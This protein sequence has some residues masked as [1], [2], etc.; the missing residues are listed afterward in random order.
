MRL[1]TF[2]GPIILLRYAL[3]LFYNHDS[4]GFRP[5]DC[6]MSVTTCVFYFKTA[7]HMSA[8]LPELNG[9]R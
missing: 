7:F 3:T 2:S 1:R 6:H 5:E 8:T 4:A 9:R